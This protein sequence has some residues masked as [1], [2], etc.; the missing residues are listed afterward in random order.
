MRFLDD[1]LVVPGTNYRFGFDAILGL[2]PVA[3]DAVTAASAISL[4]YLALQRGVPRVVLARMALNV[5]LAAVIGAIPI[6]GDL[7][8]LAFK[9][10]RRNLRLL[11][12]ATQQPTRRKTAG[13]YAVVAVFLM[14]I[15]SALV[16]PLVLMALLISH[17]AKT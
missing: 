8:D 6:L 13:D 5:A 15:A 14:V 17:L 2:L 9:A 16:L 1:G 3:G 7:F 11:E 10:N 4:F 12:R